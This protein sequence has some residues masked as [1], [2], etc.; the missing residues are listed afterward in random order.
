LEKFLKDLHNSQKIL[1]M[2]AIV[3]QTNKLKIKKLFAILALSTV[4]VSCNIETKEEAPATETPAVDTAAA[5]AVVDT[6][7]AATA[8]ADTA[9][10]AAKKP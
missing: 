9:A 8:T 2:P 10:A 1:I 3:K 5:A 7:A 6:A 4:M